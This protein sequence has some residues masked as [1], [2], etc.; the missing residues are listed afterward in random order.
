MARLKA[1]FAKVLYNLEIKLLFPAFRCRHTH[2]RT[3]WAR[4]LLVLFVYELKIKC[5]FGHFDVGTPTPRGV[6][7]SLACF[8]RISA[9]NKIAISGISMSSHPHRTVYARVLLVLFVYELKIKLLS[10]TTGCR[11]TQ[12]EAT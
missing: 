6:R 9:Q 4:V 2:T 5:Y 3:E 11:R 1:S 7:K 12:T 8:I 10:P